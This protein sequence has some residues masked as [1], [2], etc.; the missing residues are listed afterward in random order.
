MASF[1]KKIF[2]LALVLGTFVVLPYDVHTDIRLFDIRFFTSIA[3]ILIMASLA[4]DIAMLFRLPKITGYILT[5]VLISVLS[6]YKPVIE[7]V[8]LLDIK[9]LISNKYLIN[10]L[11]GFAAVVFGSNIAVRPVKSLLTRAN[12]RYY[13]FILINSG[14]SFFILYYVLSSVGVFSDLPA[15]VFVISILLISVILSSFAGELYFKTFKYSEE[16][17]EAD[18]PIPT[19]STD[20]IILFLSALIYLA[21]ALFIPGTEKVTRETAYIPFL[22]FGLAFAA[23]F[24]LARLL[25]FIHDK[26]FDIFR[27]SI[28]IIII[29]TSVTATHFDFLFYP[30][31]FL[32]ALILNNYEKL[33]EKV[34][35]SLKPVEPLSVL[36]FYT[37]AGILFSPDLGSYIYFTAAL[38]LA[39]RFFAVILNNFVNY[40]LKM[41]P[42]YTEDKNYLSLLPLGFLSVILFSV[43]FSFGHKDRIAETFYSVLITAFI[44]NSFTSTFLLKAGRALF[45]YMEHK[46]EKEKKAEEI[47]TV[48][49]VKTE[50][51]KPDFEGNFNE[52]DFADNNLNRTL[53]NLIFDLNY[54]ITTFESRFLLNRISDSQDFITSVIS[55]YKEK[56]S[57]YEKIFL[58]PGKNSQQIRTDLIQIN[59]QINSF[60]ID[61]LEDRKSAEKSFIHL[62]EVIEQFY[63]NLYKVLAKY[64]AEYVITINP[65]KAVL[66]PVRE[67]KKYLAARTYLTYVRIKHLISGTKYEKRKIKL[68]SFL[69]YFLITKS[70]GELLETLNLIGRERLELFSKIRALHKNFLLYTDELLKLNAEESDNIAL[71]SILYGR[72]LELNDT[73]SN[74]IKN[75]LEEIKVT[76]EELVNRFHF[77]LS[78]PYNE[79][80]MTLKDIHSL[81]DSVSEYTFSQNYEH[82]N[83]FRELSIESVRLWINYYLG[84]I[85]LLQKEL[86]EENL[87][88]RLNLA[89]DRSFITVA[90]DVKSLVKST[91]E[92][93][94]T[95][96]E[97][98]NNYLVLLL[99]SGKKDVDAFLN[100]FDQ[101]VQFPSLS[102]FITE[103]EKLKNSRKVKSL[104]EN[105]FREFKLI[106]ASI[107]ETI[108]LLSADDFELKN[109]IPVEK[110]VR[111]LNL[112]AEVFQLLERVLP[113]QLGELNGYL[114]NQINLVLT[115]FRNI[116]S[117]LTYNVQTLQKEVLMEDFN[118]ELVAEISSSLRNTFI[119]RLNEINKINTDIERT[120]SDNLTQAIKLSLQELSKKIN[121]I[122]GR[123]SESAARTLIASAGFRNY[124]RRAVIFI[125]RNLREIT[126]ILREFFREYLNPVFKSVWGKLVRPKSQISEQTDFLT[127]AKIKEELPFIYNRLFD[128]TPLEE[129][130]LFVGRQ[131]LET[132]F[133]E[134]EQKFVTGKPVVILVKSEPGA[135]KSSVFNLLKNQILPKDKI[136]NLSLNENI[137]TVNELSHMF[138]KAMGYVNPIAFDDIIISLNEGIKGNI[139]LLHN[140]HKSFLR[141][142]NGYDAINALLQLINLTRNNVMWV[143]TVETMAVD[144][145]NNNFRLEQIFN[146]IFDLRDF[147]SSRI[148]EIILTRHKTTGFNYEFIEEDILRLKRKFFSL[149]KSLDI[150]DFLEK[151][152]FDN[153]L[154]YSRG[155]IVAAMSYW[156]NSIVKVQKDKIVLKINRGMAKIDLSKLDILYL[157]TLFMIIIHGGLTPSDLSRVL[158]IDE[159]QS[160]ALL[161]LLYSL[162]LVILESNHATPNYYVI[163]KFY[164][165]PIKDE[166]YNRN[167][168]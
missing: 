155:N 117:I 36:T 92:Q 37:L 109:N 34:Y 136:I 120:V 147:N 156:M 158:N 148:K 103:I 63:G 65:D 121:M 113:R 76:G 126:G 81:R 127:A 39:G 108:S 78:N 139:I 142:V 1:L 138:S 43:Y 124:Y 72:Y 137:T 160:F 19:I 161:N 88:H 116:S 164:Y 157:N 106:S 67:F 27:N 12:L 71:N 73:F 114:L 22:L 91:S 23:A 70:A 100:S 28:L 44:F 131:M 145:L 101:D 7:N 77:A 87:S 149:R 98:F 61:S 68:G 50:T 58:N 159:K 122:L 20:L 104:I 29:V 3:V 49:K 151:E 54:V 33:G 165:M 74:E 85:G 93:A 99:G 102:R 66:P 152:F 163:N 123:E 95:E 24:L 31:L 118:A 105:L 32:T 35:A 38:L 14:I 141:T 134:F 11:F 40:R 90:N 144:F 57:A 133:R 15:S 4:G 53:Y 94:L 75:Y 146:H 111:F 80:I 8:D 21:G 47:K 9:S 30:V 82:A 56:F 129:G 18:I 83:K 132:R 17:F 154:D 115:E 110:N 112:R 42:F 143:I 5:G 13:T 86:Y 25:K 89:V 162:N 51:K 167:I 84:R 166:L 52:P 26:Y 79:A 150:N 59:E 140:F 128:G 130:E 10:V 153:L 168:I 41:N 45:N 6:T 64:P 107:P 125:F 97:T 96:I 62:E 16:V 119:T 48:R 2:A 60:L 135:G 69:K 46:R 55:V